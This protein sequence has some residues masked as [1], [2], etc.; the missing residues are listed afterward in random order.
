MGV[1]ARWCWALSVCVCGVVHVVLF[2]AWGKGASES[3]GRGRQ[4][5]A[6]QP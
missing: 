2:R 5:A 4:N 1:F 6:P 3:L